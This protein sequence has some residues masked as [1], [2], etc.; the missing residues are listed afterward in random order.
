VQRFGEASVPLMVPP[1]VGA[2]DYQTNVVET[3][4][5]GRKGTSVTG[6]GTAHAKGSWTTI[7]SS[8]GAPTHGIWGRV[9]D[10]GVSAALHNVL[11]DIGYGPDTSNV[12]IIIP[13]YNAGAAGLSAGGDVHAKHF[14]FPVYVPA[15]VGL[16]ARLQSNQTSKVAILAVW[17]CQRALYPWA[18][19]RVSAYGV[20]AANSRGTSVT[21]GAGTFSSW[22]Q[23]SSGTGRPH[24]YWTAAMDALADTT[25]NNQDIVVELGIGPDSG[26]VTTIYRGEL[27]ED[28]TEII[29]EVFPLIGYA[30][31]PAG[32]PLWLRAAGNNAEARGFIAYG[33]D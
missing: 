1:V 20:D 4:S 14:F 15:G 3:S 9:M 17:M 6:S 31:V 8:V 7:L 29:T 18:G 25:L 5:A 24:R 21:P 30:P 26:N 32:T 13:D 19:G 33:I 16:F 27:H 12:E 23:L 28:A 10:V 11:M 2:G 22:V